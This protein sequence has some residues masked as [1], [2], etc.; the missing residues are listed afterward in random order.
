MNGGPV[1]PPCEWP[2]NDSLLESKVIVCGAGSDEL[3]AHYKPAYIV[4]NLTQL[5]ETLI[6]F[7]SKP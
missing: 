7:V 2:K 1:S 5:K 3:I 6:D 4:D